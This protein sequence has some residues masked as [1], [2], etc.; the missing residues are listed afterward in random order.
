MAFNYLKIFG[1]SKL[2]RSRVIPCLLLQNKGLVKT[3]NFSNPQYVGDPLNAVKIFNE[4][5]VDELIF[6]DIDATSNKVSPDFNLIKKIAN[7]C[8]MPLCYGGGIRTVDDAKKI[9]KLGAEKISLSS[10]ALENPSIINEIASVIGRQSIVIVLDIKKNIFGKYEVYT[11]NGT[12][13]FKKNLDNILRELN[14]IG[15]GEL[16]INSIDRDGKMGGYDIALIEKVRNAVTFP[17]TALGGAGS[18]EDLLDIIDKFKIIGVAAG[19][20]FVFKGIYKAV[21]IS[22]IDKFYRNKIFKIANKDLE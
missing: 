20:I 11:H 2:L 22:Y 10:A 4:K 15:V 5:E 8:R 7:E 16:V 18:Q 12:K 9:I 13:K 14:D 1:K 3:V 19:S 21:L 6:L 17:L